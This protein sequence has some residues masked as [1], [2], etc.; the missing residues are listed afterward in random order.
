VLSDL[1]LAFADGARRE[2]LS[3]AQRRIGSPD[4]LP[5][6]RAVLSVCAK[7]AAPNDRPALLNI[8]QASGDPLSCYYALDALEQL[9]LGLDDRVWSR[10][11]TRWSTESAG[12]L[13]IRAV[14]AL[15]RRGDS[16]A[17]QHLARSASTAPSVILRAEAVRRLGE[18]ESFSTFEPLFA[19]VLA[20][21]VEVIDDYYAPAAEEAAFALAKVG[22]D[23]ALTELLRACLAA[24]TNP[25]SE[26]TEAYVR[27]LVARREGHDDTLV[28]HGNNWR[29]RGLPAALA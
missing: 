22:S 4:V 27:T 10:Q 15:A 13:G 18:L 24:S 11:L 1:G 26:A 2:A 6:I 16:V 21:D 9:G 29:R 14:A 28:L 5:A 8:T 25:V 12:L 19:A 7:T 3:W 17:V 20:T 23:A